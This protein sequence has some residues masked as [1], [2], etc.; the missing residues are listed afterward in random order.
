MDFETLVQSRRNVRGFRKQQ[1]ARAVIERIIE[2]AKRALISG[3]TA[4][5]KHDAAG[6]RTALE[7][8]TACDHE[9]FL[10]VAFLFFAAA[11][12]RSRAPMMAKRGT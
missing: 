11:L 8:I 7:K 3:A 6:G 2:V 10:P 5:V 12:Q 4:T 1:V 9:N